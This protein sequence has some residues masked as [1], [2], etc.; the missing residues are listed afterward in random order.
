[1]H[2]GAA[3]AFLIATATRRSL[4]QL[5]RSVLR[6]AHSCRAVLGGQLQGDIVLEAIAD[7]VIATDA[8]GRVCYSN[9]AAR[10]LLCTDERSMLG[11]P[12][13]ELMVLHEANS[14]TP[15]EHPVLQVLTSGDVVR[16]AVGSALRRPG[17]DDLI[18][19]DATAPILDVAGVLCG[20]VMVFHDITR[21]HQL[22]ERVD[23]LAWHDFL[24]GLPNRFAAQR[25]L[26]ESL[27]EARARQAPLAVMY[28]DLDKFKLVNDTL[29]HAAGDALLVS[30]AARLRACFRL[31]DVVSRQ[32]GDEFVV[33][34][35]PGTSRLDATH[36]AERINKAIEAPHRIDG[37]QVRVG[38]SIGIALFPEHGDSGDALLRHADTALHS[39]K[40][41]GRNTWCFFHQGLLASAVERREMDEGL[42]HA[43]DGAG[44]ELFY[45][46]K[47]R[48]SDGKLCGC[49]ALLRWRH[50]QWGWVA[51][52]RIIRSAEE[53][54]LIVRLGRWVLWQAL[55]QMRDWERC[56]C[57]PSSVAVNVSA[58]ELR[59]A[60]FVEHLAQQLRGAGLAAS[61][62]QLE[63]TESALMRD[64]HDGAAL[65]Y[66]IQQLGVSLAVDDFGTGYSSLSYLA[67]LPIDLLKIDRS[68]VHGIDQASTR[69]QTLLSAVL[70]LAD[71]LSLT[72]LAEG[73]ETAQEAAFLIDAGC[74]Q[75]QGYFYGQALSARDFEKAF[76]KPPSPA[77]A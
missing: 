70:A 62:L 19:E 63:L 40:A 56:G 13:A 27:V 46:P 77:P 64:M 38:C 3:T 49:E 10:R 36:A 9:S 22:Q 68:F 20:V 28:V 1:L 52:E 8:E 31:V 23:H 25:H 17:A 21:A 33:L 43:L 42:R 67:E 60:G 65:L 74:A 75:A 53:S 69:R 29:G 76:L 35:A 41:A 6:A 24:T 2:C 7:A 50:P 71:N 59:H 12:I 34:M 58:L 48:L 5:L 51:P 26:D 39:A 61:G 15:I 72:A 73:V 45:Q 47:L 11:A 32:G 57:A 66:R 4:R 44:F 18:I 37:E 30:V 54:G 55:Q 16:L 14:K